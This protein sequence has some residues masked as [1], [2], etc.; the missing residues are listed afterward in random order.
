MGNGPI[1]GTSLGAPIA[2]STSSSSGHNPVLE[3]IVEYLNKDVHSGGPTWGEVLAWNVTW[4]GND[5]V[6]VAYANRAENQTG[7]ETHIV[8]AFPTTQDA[9]NYL[10]AYD[11][12]GYKLTQTTSD[13]TKL[14]TNGDMY[15]RIAGH[16]PQTYEWWSSWAGSSQAGSSSPLFDINQWDNILYF[17]TT[18]SEAS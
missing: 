1:L 10:N 17:T 13:W 3:G 5:N 16:P 11:K 14:Y 2:T 15:S 4:S 9:T 8:L 6:T 7:G 18:W 12:T